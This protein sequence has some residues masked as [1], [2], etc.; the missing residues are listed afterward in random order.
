MIIGVVI[1]SLLLLYWL[2]AA[3]LI[4]EDE[5]MEPINIQAE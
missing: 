5:N 3:T 1:A 2:F 4:Q